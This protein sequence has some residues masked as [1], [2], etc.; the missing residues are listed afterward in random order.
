MKELTEEQIIEIRTKARMF[1]NDIMGFDEYDEENYLEE[2]KKIQDMEVKPYTDISDED[3][4]DLMEST[5]GGYTSFGHE[6]IKNLLSKEPEKLVDMFEATIQQVLDL[7]YAIN[8]FQEQLLNNLN[9]AE[10]TSE[11][12]HND[13]EKGE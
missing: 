7:N 4:T 13:I 2:T 11:L 9:N 6:F 10:N 3:L 12:N 8:S 1:I 5:V